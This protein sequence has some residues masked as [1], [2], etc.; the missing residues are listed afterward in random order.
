MKTVEK[1]YGNLDSIKI[2]TIA[3][4]IEGALDVI[5]QLTNRGIIVSI[6]IIIHFSQIFQQLQNLI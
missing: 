4:E 2:I 6:G 3:P 5:K 1:V